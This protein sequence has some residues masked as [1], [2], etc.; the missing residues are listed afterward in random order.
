ML[1]RSGKVLMSTYSNSPI[2]RMDSAEALTLVTM[3]NARRKG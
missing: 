1:A 2:G 3:M